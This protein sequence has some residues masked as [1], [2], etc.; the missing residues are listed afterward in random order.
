MPTKIPPEL[1][2]DILAGI[3]VDQSKALFALALTSKALNYEA[4]RFLYSFP[5]TATSMTLY[6][7]CR[8]VAARPIRA[9]HVKSLTIPRPTSLG[10]SDEARF[11][12]M[13]LLERLVHL[14]ELE[15]F[16]SDYIIFSRYYPFKL[17]KCTWHGL[18]E[19][20]LPFEAFVK[21]QSSLT[22]LH[23]YGCTLPLPLPSVRNLTVQG[24]NLHAV[25]P[26]CTALSSLTVHYPLSLHISHWRQR[27]FSPIL[28]NLR[29]LTLVEPIEVVEAETVNTFLPFLDNLELLCLEVSSSVESWLQR[30]EILD[31][32]HR[33]L[34]RIMKAIDVCAIPSSRLGLIRVTAHGLGGEDS[35]A[36]FRENV[37]EKWFQALPGL[38]AIEVSELTGVYSLLRDGSTSV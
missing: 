32:Q 36:A 28:S 19:C 23:L 9:V 13:D 5:K 27:N 33:K 12:V 1:Y 26:S 15:A 11:L 6:H 31:R 30:P 17:K 24:Q 7:F 16:H 37:G 22:H 25:L 2:R 35:R 38:R 8:A 34:L 18:G 29:E 10:V 4:E 14:Q 21:S 3:K 20:S